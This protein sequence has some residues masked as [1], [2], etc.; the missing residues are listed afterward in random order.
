MVTQKPAMRGFTFVEL[1]LVV[2]IMLLV[3]ATTVAGFYSYARGKALQSA[4][5]LVRSTLE[6]AHAR[7][8]GADK[9]LQYGVRLATSTNTITLFEGDTYSAVDP[10]NIDTV[11]TS[12]VTIADVSLNGGGYD[13]VFDRLVGTTDTYGTISLLLATGDSA[14]RTISVLRSG[15]IE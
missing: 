1:M 7:T 8:L 2:A 3:T 13:V 9:N 15:I 11:L 5:R 6:D 14:T 12:Y 10:N 4:E